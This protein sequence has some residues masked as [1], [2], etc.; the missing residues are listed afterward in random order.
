MLRS[1][2]WCYVA[3]AGSGLGRHSHSPALLGLTSGAGASR[4]GAAPSRLQM[5]R[6]SLCSSPAMNMYVRLFPFPTA[7]RNIESGGDEG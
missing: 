1:W 7:L 2:W 4:F 6:S 5:P 3:S